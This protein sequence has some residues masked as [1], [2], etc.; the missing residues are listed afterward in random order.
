MKNIAP[1]LDFAAIAEC[2]SRGAVTSTFRSHGASPKMSY[3][4][5]RGPAN[6][7]ARAA[8]V[9]MMIYPHADQWHL[10]LTER[11]PHLA[12]HAGQVSLPGGALE[13][14]ESSWQAALRELEEELAVPCH[15]VHAIGVLPPV[16][17][18]HSNFAV[19]PWLARCD[20]RPTFQM[21]PAEVAG[22]VELPLSDLLAADRSHTI[23][24]VRGGLRF[25]APVFQWHGATIWVATY[26][27]LADLAELLQQSTQIR[28]PPRVAEPDFS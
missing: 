14:G 2:L 19:T 26:V 25:S 21:N 27:M 12:A 24:I 5:H 22:L 7:D 20:H 23:E 13:Q 6:Y 28:E 9:I 4:R 15:V 11:Q 8:A 17:I 3:G 18:F 10:V 16:Y 1:S